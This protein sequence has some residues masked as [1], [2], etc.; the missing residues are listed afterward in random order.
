MPFVEGERKEDFV[1]LAEQYGERF[2]FHA[3]TPDHRVSAALGCYDPVL[4]GAIRIEDELLV[5]G[6]SKTILAM[7]Q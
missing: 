2:A 1:L 4:R 3:P 6:L 7:R 5:L